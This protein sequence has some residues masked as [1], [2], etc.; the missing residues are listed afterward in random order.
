M[1]RN[2]ARKWSRI[3]R[4]LLLF[5]WIQL[6]ASVVAEPPP[7]IAYA[8]PAGG[9]RGTTF[10]MEIGG[11]HLDAYPVDYLSGIKGDSAGIHAPDFN[12]QVYVSGEGVTVKV[13]SHFRQ[14]A[15]RG[16][17]PRIRNRQQ[18]IEQT[19][20]KASPRMRKLMQQ[21]LDAI[22]KCWQEQKREQQRQ[23]LLYKDIQR[24]Q[25]NPQ[26]A[27][28]LTVEVTIAPDAP[29]G[30][31]ELR[32]ITTF[33]L[34]N[35][36]YFHVG[37]LPEV[38]EK[39]PNDDHQSRTVKIDTL[40][41]LVNGQI[42]PGDI[43]H[44]TF[45]AKKGQHLVIKT[46][47]RKLIPYLADA[48]PGWFQ[49]TLS[50]LNDEG[51]EIAYIDDYKYDP[52]PVMFFDVQ[53]TGMYTLKI[54]DAIY[55]GREDFVYRIEIGE[56]PFIT[57][58][59]PLGGRAGS[60]VN[61][62]LRG[63]NL[64]RNTLGGVLPKDCPP[65]RQITVGREPLISNPMPFAVGHL[66]EFMET[67]PNDGKTKAHKIRIPVIVNGRI[68]EPGDWDTYAFYG[69]RGQKIVIEVQAR[70]LGSMLDSVV[71]LFSASGKLIGENDDYVHKEGY[72]HVDASGLITHH[73]DSYLIA[74]L[75]T[76]G[77]YYVL[78]GDIQAKG[79]EEHGYRMRISPAN[80]DFELR[81]E[82][83]GVNIAP[84]GVAPFA[85]HVM[86]KDDFSGPIKLELQNVPEGFI[87][88]TD[89]IPAGADK[90]RFT[91]S[92]PEELPEQM[93][94][95]RIIGTSRVGNK[96]LRHEALP[97]DNEMQAFL[98]CHLVPA[99]ELVLAPSDPA[100]FIFDVSVPEK[101]IRLPIDKEVWVRVV[102]KR[103]KGVQV[104]VKN[105]KF[106]LD[107]PPDGIL[108][109]KGGLNLKNQ[110][111]GFVLKAD[112]TLKPGTKETL[113]VK[114]VSRKGKI[115]TY[116]PL[117]AIPVQVVGGR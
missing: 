25:F 96:T 43:D 103:N 64:P 55:R 12:P 108:L 81:L 87:M 1:N 37:A 53:K 41:V 104:N 66:P 105:L 77:I 31:R 9:Q 102:A 8:Y 101:G 98:Y 62:T 44:F 40:P 75:P 107:N 114:A 32:L 73:A 16:D 39:E 3:L 68:Q 60:S 22:K 15:D 46:Y 76:D 93:V 88:S 74:K 56:L 71:K 5:I 34:S 113:I 58:I 97:A 18:R 20:N 48:V 109:V 17:R 54:R 90:L 51:K 86:R 117:P 42:F 110:K 63:K 95:P 65:L 89:T 29:L 84:G 19:I 45:K 57:S 67:E 36:I 59:Y 99:R 35:P 92:A 6:V 79:S 2:K 10:K 80:P 78:I 28:R 115:E 72:L 85:L 24:K 83:S 49:A 7:H 47:A 14:L 38:K 112:N 111:G 116:Y 4:I 13:L 11:Q 30:E 91:L 50:L 82:P 106:V 21:E 52:D 27:E 33:G 26:L 100:P 69:K 23:R 94:Y 70:Y 61:I